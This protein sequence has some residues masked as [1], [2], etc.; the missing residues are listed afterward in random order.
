MWM[1]V[2]VVDVDVGGSTLVCAPF[3]M[4]LLRTHH[5]ILYANAGNRA[6]TCRAY[7]LFESTSCTSKNLLVKVI[8]QF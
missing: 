5:T 3:L 6:T 2:W 4:T 1:R 8:N 7:L